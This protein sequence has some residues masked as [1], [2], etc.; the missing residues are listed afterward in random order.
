MIQ[1][2]YLDMDICFDNKGFFH[3]KLFDKRD[4]FGF[5]VINFP[6]MTYSNIPSIPSYGIYLSQIL[7]ICRICTDFADFCTAIVKISNEFLN[8]RFDKSKLV[9]KFNKFVDNY[10]KEWAKFGELPVLPACLT[11]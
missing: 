3:S 6:C 10:E 7:R 4:H 8:K 5:N 2:D 9:K 1:A 11:Q